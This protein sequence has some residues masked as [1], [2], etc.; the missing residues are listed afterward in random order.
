MRRPRAGRG[1]VLGAALAV[2]V[3]ALAPLA[4]CAHRGASVV[5][6]LPEGDWVVVPR[7][8]L[9]PQRGD[10]DCGPAA[11]ATVLSRWGVPPADAWRAPPEGR[12]V[13]AGELRD[14]ARHLGFRS[15]VFEGSFDDLDFEIAS[16]RP[17]VVGLV[18]NV[19]E[20]RWSHF[21][22]IVG[23]E[24]G[25]ARWLLADPSQ[26]VQVLGREALQRQWSASGF[27]TL[28]L[29]PGG[30]ATETGARGVRAAL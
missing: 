12:G 20:K 17:I 9:Y 15:F 22:V 28:V 14:V 13:T 3:A 10:T 6:D 18:R 16:A 11:L 4:G 25:G 19:D 27:V 7:V 24:A 21:A 2:C 5:A 26:G 23:R 8:I 1:A 29:E 30:G